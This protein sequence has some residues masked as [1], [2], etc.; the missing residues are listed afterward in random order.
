MLDLKRIAR[1]GTIL[2][3]F[4]QSQ[5][6]RSLVSVVEIYSPVCDVHYGT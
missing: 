5:K 1:T 4:K 6:S 3:A 2:K